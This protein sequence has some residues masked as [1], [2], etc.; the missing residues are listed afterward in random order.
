[1]KNGKDLDK[2]PETVEFYPPENLDAA[3]IGYLYKRDTGRKLSIAFTISY[4][5]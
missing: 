2:V 5:P 1:M 3:E 4:L